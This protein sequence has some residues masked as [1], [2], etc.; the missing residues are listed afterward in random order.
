MKLSLSSTASKADLLFLLFYKGEKLSKESAKMLDKNLIKSIEARFTAKDFEGDE[1]QILTL[2]TDGGTF[3]KVTLVG[4]GEKG[5]LVPQTTERLG[6]TIVAI[7]KKNKAR[8]VAIQVNSEDLSELAYGF[9]LGEYEFKT[10]KKADPKAISVED[11]TF[12]SENNKTNKE[13]VNRV[14]IFMRASALTRSLINT[15]A[16]DLNTQDL[17]NEAQKVAKKS[18][19]KITILNEAKLKKLG[20]GALCGVGQG[21]TTG[22]RMVLLEY[23]NKSAAKEPAIAFIG[24]GII[25]D[26]GGMNLKPT[27]HIETMKEDMAGSATVLGTL[28]AIAE[29]KLPG[30]FL[31][32]LAIAENA[33]SDRALHPGDVVR[34]YNG[35][36]IEVNNTDAEGRLVL[37]DALSYTEKNYHP[38]RMVNIATL[39]GAVTVALGYN[40][41]G[42][43]GNDEKWMDDVMDAGK[44]VHERYWSLPLDA[45]FVKA[46]KGDFTDLKNAT[47][48]IRAGTI[49]GAA[50]LKEFVEKTPWVHL[51]TGGTAWA[52]RPTS[53]THYGATGV[54]LRTFIE[55]A[56]RYSA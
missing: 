32:V 52:E 17:V 51:D 48:G 12:I 30:Y 15:S 40:I 27:G 18:K 23:R 7:A 24:K 45:D 39:T 25:F 55:L 14:E 50:F 22:P 13:L 5:K 6:G 29:L 44:K 33:I 3:K 11:V 8:N 56:Q 21:A 9:V 34:A 54:C 47:D 26:S 31:G 43:M 2:F 53:N 41:T 20:C 38:K 42:V 49:M 28:Q 1:G 19:L 36:T 16:G 10:Y 35:K 4:R 37:A 46:T